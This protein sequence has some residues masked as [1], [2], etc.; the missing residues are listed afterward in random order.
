MLRDV[1]VNVA[2]SAGIS[3]VSAVISLYLYGYGLPVAKGR[4]RL[5][6]GGESRKSLTRSQSL[7]VNSGL[8]QVD[9]KEI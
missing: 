3:L 5:R 8:P 7:S 2:S 1:E 9:R 4:E 6:R